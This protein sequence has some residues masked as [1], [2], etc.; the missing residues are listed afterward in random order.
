MFSILSP[1]YTGISL[2]PVI[3]KLY[4]TVIINRISEHLEH[5]ELM[6]NEE[7]G[8]RPGR[9][10]LDHV[11]FIDSRKAFDCVQHCFLLH[12]LINKEI[13]GDIYFAI[14]CPHT[15]PLS[16]VRVVGN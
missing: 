7:N 8:F 11:V 13:A 14:K 5:N 6:C 9:S 10:C 12:K 16:S 15:A 4:S 1:S 2:L 3:A